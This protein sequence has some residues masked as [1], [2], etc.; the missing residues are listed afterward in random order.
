ME[1][2]ASGN[3]FSAR[4]KEK[5]SVVSD[6]LS[7]TIQACTRGCRGV[8]VG[9]FVDL[10]L[11][12]RPDSREYLFQN[13]CCLY[14]TSL[15]IYLRNQEQSLKCKSASVRHADTSGKKSTLYSIQAT[16]SS[17]W[18]ELLYHPCTKSSCVCL[19]QYWSEILLIFKDA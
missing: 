16:Q 14:A 4:R 12:Q 18:P 19:D 10:N 1:F 2:T 15:T 11:R 9:F 6:F 5:R 8:A 7:A 13:S 17:G 3:D